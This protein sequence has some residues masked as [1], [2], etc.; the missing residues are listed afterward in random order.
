MI[1]GYTTGVFDM[2]HVGHLNLLERARAQCDSL[3][4]GVNSDE[5]TQQYKGKLPVIP[6]EDRCRIVGAL[7]A[8]DRVVCRSVRDDLLAWKQHQFNRLFHGDDWKGREPFATAQRELEKQGV[9]VI[10]LPYT[11]NISSTSLQGCEDRKVEG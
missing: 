3:I 8:V 7:K 1:I 5:L 2:F 6:F 9:Q 11:P 10:F 4:V